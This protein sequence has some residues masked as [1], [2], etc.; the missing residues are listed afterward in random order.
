LAIPLLTKAKLLLLQFEIPLDTVQ[1]ALEKATQLNLK[2]ILNPAP[3]RP[4]GADLLSKVDI[5][6]PNQ[7]ELQTLEQHANGR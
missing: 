7:T 4:V 1:Y 5:L 3:A 2:V 6:V